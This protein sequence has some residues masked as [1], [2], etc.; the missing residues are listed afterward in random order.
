LQVFGNEVQRRV[1]RTTDY[2]YINWEKE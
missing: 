2:R 1:F